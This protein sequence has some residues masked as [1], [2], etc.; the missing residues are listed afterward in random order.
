ME[1]DKLNSKTSREYRTES[2]KIN[3]R[4]IYKEEGVLL[5]NASPYNLPSYVTHELYLIGYH[6][7]SDQCKIIKLF[8]T[9]NII[10]SATYDE[11]TIRLEV[12]TASIIRV[13]VEAS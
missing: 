8:G 7:K 11:N 9:E 4:P 3:I 12:D 10:K 6:I 13:F 2:G 5:L 1:E